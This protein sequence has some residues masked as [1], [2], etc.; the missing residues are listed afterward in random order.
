MS[1]NDLVRIL[2]SPD[3]YFSAPNSYEGWLH[4]SL[5]QQRLLDDPVLQGKT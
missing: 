1:R 4:Q 5:N 2:L 3:Y